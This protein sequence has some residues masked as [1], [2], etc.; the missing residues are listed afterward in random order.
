LNDVQYGADNGL[1]ISQP[2]LPVNAFSQITF[3][4]FNNMDPSGLQTA[5]VLLHRRMV[6]HVHIHGG[7][8]DDRRRG[9]KKQCGEEIICQSGGKL[10]QNICRSRSH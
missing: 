8:N 4:G 6:P 7:S 5:D 3:I 1:Q 2:A 9:S 10:G